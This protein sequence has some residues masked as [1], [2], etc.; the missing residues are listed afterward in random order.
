SLPI[1]ALLQECLADDPDE[2]M[3]DAAVLAERL[4]AV[5]RLPAAPVVPPV[6]APEADAPVA[7]TPTET[8]DE[9]A[10]S[11][12]D[13]VAEGNRRLDQRKYAAALRAYN[14]ALSAGYD[15]ATVCRQRA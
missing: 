7:E 9:A 12:A 6:S 10:R 15:E 4:D 14:E 2:R 1:I 3:A 13:W 11:A 8:P 5:L